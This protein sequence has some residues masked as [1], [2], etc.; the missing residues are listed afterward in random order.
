MEMTTG[1]SNTK[2]IKQGGINLN[3]YKQMRKSFQVKLELQLNWTNNDPMDLASCINIIHKEQRLF[4]REMHINDDFN[5]KN[6]SV[7][8]DPFEN[9]NYNEVFKKIINQDPL[10][11]HDLIKDNLFK[12][13]QGDIF[14][15]TGEDRGLN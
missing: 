9:I 10:V 5:Y 8:V 12:F 15:P 6:K 14:I 7:I 11:W 1:I 3:F 2:E 13:L 4:I